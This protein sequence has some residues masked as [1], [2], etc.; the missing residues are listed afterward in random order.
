MKRVNAIV[1]VYYPSEKMAA[2]IKEI[3][4]QVDRIF[5]CDNSPKESS[6]LFAMISN[7]IYLYFGKNLGISG[8]MNHVLKDKQ[9]HWE[10]GEYIVFFDQDSCIPDSYIQKL[11]TEYES[12]SNR[13]YDLGCIGP[14]YFNYSNNRLETAR[15]KK[16]ITRHSFQVPN[17]ITSSML[18]EYSSLKSIGFW[19]ENIFL[20]WADFELCWRLRQLKKICCLTDKLVL[21]HQVGIGER[22]I[23]FIHLRIWSPIREYYQIR[24][25]LYL[26]SQKYVPVK[27]KLRL[28]VGF[29]IGLLFH[30][31]FLG[32]SK[33]RLYYIMKGIT[34]YQKNITGSLDS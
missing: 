14:V 22:K 28:I 7:K 15:S 5:I 30:M 26:M 33:K 8:A 12:I 10:Q 21:N 31:L 4:S 13:G 29:T 17:I 1:T 20:D 9:Y 2:N 16:Q 19:N 6:S 25:G 3:A 11:V 27:F 23:G 34:D 18:C 24:D 32:E